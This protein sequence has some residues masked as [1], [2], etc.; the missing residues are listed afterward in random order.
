M[1]DIFERIKLDSK[2]EEETFLKYKPFGSYTTEEIFV[3]NPS[4]GEYVLYSDCPHKEIPVDNIAKG[5][6]LNYWCK[7][8]IRWVKEV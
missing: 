8:T 2:K 5:I 3:I 1:L 6:F 7:R 4:T